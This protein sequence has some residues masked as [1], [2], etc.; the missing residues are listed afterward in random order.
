MFNKKQKKPSDDQV[1]MKIVTDGKTRDI[2]IKELLLSQNL[3]L[4]ALTS[5]LI[6]KGVFTG[7]ELLDEIKRIQEIH[8]GKTIDKTDLT[9][10]E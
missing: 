2:T 10:D 3:S 5:L 8:T 9:S 6:K 7:E 4:E 1:I